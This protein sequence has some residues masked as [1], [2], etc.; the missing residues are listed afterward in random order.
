MYYYG[1]TVYGNIYFNF[2]SILWPDSCQYTPVIL[3]C[4][5]LVTRVK[6]GIWS[7]NFLFRP[8]CCLYLHQTLK[9]HSGSLVHSQVSLKSEITFLL[10]GVG[11]CFLRGIPKWD[12]WNSPRI[13]CHLS[14]LLHS[15]SAHE[16]EMLGTHRNIIHRAEQ[17]ISVWVTVDLGLSLKHHSLIVQR[18]DNFWLLLRGEKRKQIHAGLSTSTGLFINCHPAAFDLH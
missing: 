6:N 8:S 5:W 7:R 18:L 15:S 2:P 4:A 14:R 12:S 13:F 10:V 16:L 17:Q 1:I 9:E 3:F 11:Q